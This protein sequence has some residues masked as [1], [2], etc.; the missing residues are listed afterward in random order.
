MIYDREGVARE[1]LYLETFVLVPVELWRNLYFQALRSQEEDLIECK[2][3]HLQNWWPDIFVR[4]LR[5]LERV[6]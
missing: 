4:I 1:L 5:L 6:V 2:H 3:W